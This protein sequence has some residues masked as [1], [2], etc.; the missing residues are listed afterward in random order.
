MRLALTLLLTPPLQLDLQ[1]VG[2]SGLILLPFFVELMGEGV[3]LSRRVGHGPLELGLVVGCAQF[4][5]K[6]FGGFYEAFLLILQGFA[7]TT[8]IVSSETR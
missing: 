1:H 3:V 5:C 6:I 2:H 8:A 7:G 4:A